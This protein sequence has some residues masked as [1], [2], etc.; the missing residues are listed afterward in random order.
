M[1][2]QRTFCFSSL[3]FDSINEHI[4]LKIKSHI[5]KN[6]RAQG[7]LFVIS[8]FTII[9]GFLAKQNSSRSSA[10]ARKSCFICNRAALRASQK[11]LP[12]LLARQTRWQAI[13]CNISATNFRKRTQ[14]SRP[15]RCFTASACAWACTRPYQRICAR[16]CFRFSMRKRRSKSLP[17]TA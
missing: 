17:K 11:R 1:R 9:S 16:C 15:F 12:Y 7:A 14:C 5:F 4:H 13:F 6:R 10:T 2:I 3:S 8:E